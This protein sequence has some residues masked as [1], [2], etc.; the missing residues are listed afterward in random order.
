[1]V[2]IQSLFIHYLISG[3]EQLNV[4]YRREKFAHRASEEK[5]VSVRILVTISTSLNS[6]YL[7]MES[8]LIIC[9]DPQLRNKPDSTVAC[10]FGLKC[11]ESPESLLSRSLCI[12]DCGR[13]PKRPGWLSKPLNLSVVYL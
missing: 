12:R 3:I 2:T 13:T 5:D 8:G 6:V 4:A 9:R 10:R 11:D 1:M 7:L